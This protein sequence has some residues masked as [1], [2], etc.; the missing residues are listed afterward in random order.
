M[1]H[2]P[3]SKKG[4]LEG[5]SRVLRE[6]LRTPKF[7]KTIQILLNELD[8]ENAPLVI[9]VM[10]T[11]DPALFLSVLSAT[12]AFINMSTEAL[13]EL[14]IQLSSFPPSLFRSFLSQ[15]SEGVNGEKL[16]E[17][18]GRM[19]L[20]LLNVYIGQESE[21]KESTFLPGEDFL[22]GFKGVF[23]DQDALLQTNFLD[24]FSSAG[25]AANKIGKEA[26]RKNS[27][28][29]KAVKDI[30][31]LIKTFLKE[32]PEFSANIISPLIAAGKEGM[33]SDG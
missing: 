29:Q 8:P 2:E 4:I 13:C 31:I 6:L 5:G 23:E 15:I 32:C 20:L 17:A 18:T 27:A 25:K 28:T 22:I 7:K 11:E 14:L 16:G 3:L 19:L 21:K 9:K 30:A 24:V 1:D 12:P 26:R 33:K 10:A